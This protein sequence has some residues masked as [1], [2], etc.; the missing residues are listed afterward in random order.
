MISKEIIYFGKKSILAC[1][2][3]CHKA[4]GISKRKNILLDIEDE[5]DI[6]YL[7]D[8]ELDIA[9]LN[10]NTYEGDDG[11]PVHKSELLN[12]WCCRECE[13]SS[14]FKANEKDID[15]KLKNF[16]NRIYNIP[17]KYINLN[18]MN[19]ES[20]LVGFENGKKLYDKDFK[21]KIYIGRKHIIKINPSIKNISMS[22]IEGFLEGAYLNNISKA[23]LKN[24]VEFK[25]AKNIVEKIE[26]ALS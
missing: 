19:N 8:D 21:N 7:S 15:F 9:P 26:I 17:I 11:K 22:F 25:G 13:R 24:N 23:E 10:P 6:V 18:S 20:N 14:I 4:F 2:G 12:K 3:K 16:S 5:D 1:D